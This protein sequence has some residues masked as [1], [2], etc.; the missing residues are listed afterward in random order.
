MTKKE[1]EDLAWELYGITETIDV[2]VFKSYAAQECIA[3]IRKKYP[4]I[5]EEMKYLE[6]Q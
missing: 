3:N 2:P 6:E 1:A 5:D 4:K